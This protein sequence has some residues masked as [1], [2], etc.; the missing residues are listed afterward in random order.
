MEAWRQRSYMCSKSSPVAL[1]GVKMS[2]SMQFMLT[3]LEEW[4]VAMLF[5]IATDAV[6]IDCG[7]RSRASC[8]DNLLTHYRQLYASLAELLL[9][10][11]AQF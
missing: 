11:T 8:H 6:S 3:M 7:T 1:G 5:V 2:M 4:P 9:Q 10:H